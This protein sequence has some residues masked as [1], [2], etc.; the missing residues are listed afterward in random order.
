MADDFLD[1]DG[2]VVPPEAL[3]ISRARALARLVGRGSL[4]YVRL[5]ECRRAA[6]A[7]GRPSETVVIETD[8]E[9]PQVMAHEMR[10]VE[11]IAAVFH[12]E[13]E[14]Y[15]EVLALRKSFPRAPHQNLRLTELPRSLCLYDRPWS[16]VAIRWT[17]ATFIGRIRYWL[18]QTA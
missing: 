14:W 1:P 11:R 3:T 8:V 12:E 15:P 13:D 18:A 6:G 9:R 17:P 7:D 4:P 16:E 10:R 5:L 2:I